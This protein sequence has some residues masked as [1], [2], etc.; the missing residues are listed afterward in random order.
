[1][2]VMSQKGNALLIVLVLVLLLGAAGYFL[3][4]QGYLAKY[5]PQGQTAQ[6]DVFNYAASGSNQQSSGSNQASTDE[7]GNVSSK[8]IDLTVNY[9]ADGSTLTSST[10]NVTGT[11]T[12]GADVFVNDQAGKADPNGNF[13]IK[14]TLDEGQ[15]GLVVIANDANGNVAERDLSVNVQTF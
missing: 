8:N 7:V 5:L 6:T 13:S 9:P 10:I 4:S 3:Y 15:N 12:P 2:I 1:M 14:I 11:T